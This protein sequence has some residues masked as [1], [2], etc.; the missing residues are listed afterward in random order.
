[1][2]SINDVP[3]RN[4]ILFIRRQ[5]LEAYIVFKPRKHDGV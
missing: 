1:M 3:A 4:L 2:F 5:F